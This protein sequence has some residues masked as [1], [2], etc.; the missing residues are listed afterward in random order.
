MIFQYYQQFAFEIKA[1]LKL[2]KLSIDPRY[3]SHITNILRH[4]LL[5]LIPSTIFILLIAG[6][7]ILMLP[8][9]HHRVNPV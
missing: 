2:L 6:K 3:H 1:V 8:R 7:K 5:T 9:Y 4:F